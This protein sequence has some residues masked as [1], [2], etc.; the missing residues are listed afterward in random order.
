VKA[1]L[2]TVLVSCLL[3]PATVPQGLLSSTVNCHISADMKE[4]GLALWERGWEPVEICDAL[5]FSASSLYR[6]RRI[7]EE[8]GTVNRPPSPLCGRPRILI[9]AVLNDIHQLLLSDPHLY[10]D[11]LLLLLAVNHGLMIS[12]SALQENLEKAGLSRKILQK[13]AIERNDELRADFRDFIENEDHFHGDGSEFVFL[14]ETSKDERS[15]AQLQG[16]SL[17][18]ERAILKDV[19]VRGDRYSIL[20]A[21]TLDGYMAVHVEMDAFDSLQ[22]FEFVADEVVCLNF[23]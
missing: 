15:Y 2:A 9:R 23:D 17:A 21:L 22:F 7:F 14:D 13:I 18:G 11:E 3:S 20:A 5:G 10:L 16:R 8:R 1:L 12:R 19:F 4:C 6:W